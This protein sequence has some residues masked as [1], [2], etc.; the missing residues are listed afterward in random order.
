[1]TVAA[2]IFA[3]EP[4]SALDD[5][6]GS[7]AA[8]HLAIVADEG[9]ASSVLVVSFDPDGAVATAV[10]GVAELV[11]PA[12][13][14]GG[15]VA[16]LARGVDAALEAD[17]AVT[18]VLLWPA[19]VTW[20]DEWLVRALIAARSHHRPAI[21]RPMHDGVPDWP[22]LF[23]VEFRGALDGIGPDRMPD[24]VLADVA[25]KGVPVQVI[26]TRPSA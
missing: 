4:A 10:D 18:A 8:R 11:T 21:V 1:M 26:P 17:E 20:A 15:P 23:P 25:A 16:Q 19:R 2:V 5:V 6:H 3:S 12:G 13:V 22:A 14:E 24:D 7:P 9:G